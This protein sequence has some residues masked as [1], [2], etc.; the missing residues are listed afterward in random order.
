MP[1]QNDGEKGREGGDDLPAG[2]IPEVAGEKQIE[3][4]DEE[5]KSG[6]CESAS[7]DAERAA[8][9]EAEDAFEEVLVLMEGAPE[10]VESE[11]DPEAEETSRRRRWPKRK[12][13]QEVRRVSAA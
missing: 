6:A 11:G 8:D 5:G 1:G 9:S 13:P 4:G 7:E 12:I 3:K 10:E 2:E